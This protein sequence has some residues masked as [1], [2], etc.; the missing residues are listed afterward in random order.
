MREALTIEIDGLCMHGTRHV[1]PVSNGRGIVFFNSGAQPRSARGELYVQLAD[2]LAQNGFSCFRFDMPGLGDS[3]GE[4]PARHVDLYQLIQDGGHAPCAASLI[5]VLLDMHKLE[6]VILVGIC[7]GAMTSIFATPMLSGRVGGLVLLDL[8]F[9]SVRP[10]P[11]AGGQQ[12]SN[13]G[14]AKN[15]QRL[16]QWKAALHDRILASRW[17]PQITAFYHKL[18]RLK[19]AI[20]P[21][22]LP[23]DANLRLLDV[24]T[25]VLNDG[26]PAL[27][28]GARPTTQ[29]TTPP[30]DYLAHLRRRC[31]KGWQHIEIPGTTHSFVENGGGRA[32]LATVLKWLSALE[33]P[34]RDA[35]PTEPQ[36]AKST[37][38][39]FSAEYA[40][41]GSE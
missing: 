28:L 9:F 17:E 35:Q 25:K 10:P 39:S 31:P 2:G 22:R 7:G 27:L 5:Q 12:P 13:S 40:S 32:V 4:L 41:A 36:P 21:Q 38:A 34:C 11:A 14:L 18:R 26:V 19:K 15:R 3:D 29:Q 8:L 30:F 23:A 16:K 37:H 24:F 20:V 33:C 1:G 6:D